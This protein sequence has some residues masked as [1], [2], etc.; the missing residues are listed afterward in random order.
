M[1]FLRNTMLVVTLAV[2]TGCAAVVPMASTEQDTASKTFK[3]PSSNMAGLYVYR[4]SSYGKALKKNIK[5][6]GVVIGESASYTYFHK[7]I[8]PG[9]HTLSTESEFGDNELPF[10]ADAGKNY[11]FHQYIK[12]GVFKGGANLEAV[13]ETTGQQCVLECKEAK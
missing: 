4:N 11:Y 1:T 2:L 6:D 9:A 13:N 12:M 3:V 7:E 10:T 5:L 8:T